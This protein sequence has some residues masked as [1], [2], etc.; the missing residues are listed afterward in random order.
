MANKLIVLSNQ[1][2]LTRVVRS[3]PACGVV[4]ENEAPN[5]EPI[6]LGSEIFTFI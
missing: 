6:G 4:A 1:S 3:G 5:L 2:S